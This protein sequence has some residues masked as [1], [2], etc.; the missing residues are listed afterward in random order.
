MFNNIFFFSVYL[1]CYTILFKTHALNNNITTVLLVYTMFDSFV[2][3][4]YLNFPS[5]LL[6]VATQTEF[7]FRYIVRVFQHI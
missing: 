2:G 1:V 4:S 5:N 7:S 3:K 6:D